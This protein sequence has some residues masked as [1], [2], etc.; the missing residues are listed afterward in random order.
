MTS[1]APER[2]RDYA[3]FGSTFVSALKLLAQD[4]PESSIFVVSQFGSPTS[5]VRMLS[6][7]ERKRIRRHR[8]VCLPRSPRLARPRRSLL[9]SRRSS[10]AMRRSSKPAASSSR[11][12]GTTAAPSAG[13]S[14]SGVLECRCGSLLDQGQREGSSRRLGGDE[15]CWPRTSLGLVQPRPPRAASSIRSSQLRPRRRG[16]APADLHERTDRGTG[17]THDHV[18][19]AKLLV[20]GCNQVGDLDRA[21][22]VRY[23]EVVSRA[24]VVKSA[25]DANHANTVARHGGGTTVWQT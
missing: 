13:S 22:E 1:S 4:A 7:A 3:A 11:S 16:D 2:R 21:R 24:L 8:A 20:L 25:R 5:T 9:G 15:A 14:T 10:M 6:P 12:A 23:A 19:D 18:D 17:R